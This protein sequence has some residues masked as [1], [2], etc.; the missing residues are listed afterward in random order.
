MTSVTEAPPPT[1]ATAPPTAPGVNTKRVCSVRV[2]ADQRTTGLCAPRWTRVACPLVYGPWS[3]RLRETKAALDHPPYQRKWYAYKGLTNPYELLHVSSSRAR[4]HEN[5]ATGLPLSRSYF[6][7]WEM[8]H[9]FDLLPNDAVHRPLR[10]AHF[11]EGPGGF[12]EAV[13]HYRERQCATTDTRSSASIHAH[14]RTNDT[15][16]GITLRSTRRDVPGWGKSKRL[17][18][19]YPQ[20]RLHYGKDHT[21]DLYKVANITEFA[22]CAGR[23]ECALVTG[24]GGI[25]YSV[26]FAHQ[27]PLSFRLLLCQV[28]GAWLT[29]R[30]GGAF[31]CK[32]FDTYE[33]FT[34]ELLWLVALSFDVV[35]VVKPHTSRPAN[36][37]RYVVAKGFRGVPNAVLEYV[38]RLIRDWR[39][40][41]H[42]AGV[43]HH[44]VPAPF[45]TVVSEYN[46]WYARSQCANIERCLGIIDAELEKHATDY[47]TLFESRGT[48]PPSL[49]HRV[50]ATR[51]PTIVQEQV[52]AATGWCHKYGVGLNPA[53]RG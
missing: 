1:T 3:A 38:H 17:M 12:M 46:E 2:P 20:I 42:L 51:F 21:G 15:Y 53:H 40:N 9:D 24:D 18:A 16:T 6:K 37:E 5:V 11:A 33:P 34:V 25:D 43:L 36:S 48:E 47:D 39:P 10:T 50:L 14:A 19:E 30:V 45:R 28:Y 22:R 23:N 31:V 7:M 52:R 8:L 27:E 29:L 26:D 13:A 35:H 41:E 44:P 49:S 4:M 32:F